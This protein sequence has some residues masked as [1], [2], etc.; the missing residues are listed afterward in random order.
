MAERDGKVLRRREHREE[1]E[2]N[3]DWTWAGRQERKGKKKQKTEKQAVCGEGDGGKH[4]LLWLLIAAVTLLICCLRKKNGEKN[5]NAV[6][7]LLR[8]PED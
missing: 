3:K 1:S 7:P 2:T 4:E 5:Q 6:Q 8:G